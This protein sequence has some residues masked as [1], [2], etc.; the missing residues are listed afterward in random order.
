MSP[1]D[2]TLQAMLL[3]LAPDDAARAQLLEAHRQLEKDLLRLADP[4]PPP[5]FL[6][7]VMTRVATEPAPMTRADVRSAI[8]I[9]GVTVSLAVGAILAGGDPSGTF[10][11]LVASLVLKLR[12]GVVAVGSGLSA[13]WTTAAMPTVVVLSAMLAAALAAFRRALQP[14]A[15][16]VVS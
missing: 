6:H 3:E 9:I 10:G 14:S 13:L 12:E 8:V 4:A 11:L 5:D 7:Q 15:A 1:E 16:K 2:E